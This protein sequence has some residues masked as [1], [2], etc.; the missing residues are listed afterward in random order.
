M[1]STSMVMIGVSRFMVPPLNRFPDSVEE[2]VGHLLVGVER[3][4][5][6]GVS[7]VQQERVTRISA[8]VAAE[9]VDP[10][11]VVAGAP[12]QALAACG[13]AGVTLPGLRADGAGQPSRSRP[14]PTPSI[15]GDGFGYGPVDLP[16]LLVVFR[17]NLP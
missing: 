17:L 14:D 12:I 13:D 7:G 2:S 4:L 6:V 3:S 1:I 16:H 10:G 8:G 11:V 9:V 15:L 5:Q